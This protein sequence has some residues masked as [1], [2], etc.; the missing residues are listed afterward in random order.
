MSVLRRIVRRPVVE[1]VGQWPAH[2]P[3][4]LRRVH[5]ARG[6]DADSAMPRLADL[7][8]ASGLNGIET[9]VDL[10]AAAIARDAKGRVGARQIWRGDGQRVVQVA[11]VE[12]H[13][14]QIAGDCRIAPP[15]GMCGL[16]MADGARQVIRSRL[17]KSG[18]SANR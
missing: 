17:A 2:W 15:L 12:Q 16:E 5:A 14:N 10:L 1:P 7:L 8:P 4:V 3:E 13:G 11:R 6:S 18:C 9:A